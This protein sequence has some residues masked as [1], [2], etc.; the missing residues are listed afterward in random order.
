MNQSYQTMPRVA[1]NHHQLSYD[2]AI[3]AANLARLIVAA[4][5]KISELSANGSNTDA[6]RRQEDEK[7]F[8]EE[9]L[10]TLRNMTGE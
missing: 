6:I 1:S 10:S 8:L 5:D 4:R 2:Q 3:V 9:T 7:F